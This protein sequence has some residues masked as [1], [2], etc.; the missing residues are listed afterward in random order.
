MREYG[1]TPTRREQP[2]RLPYAFIWIVLGFV[3]IGFVLIGLG[4]ATYDPPV[5]SN[6]WQTCKAPGC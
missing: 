1:Y 3:L 2:A 6:V 5:V 4:V